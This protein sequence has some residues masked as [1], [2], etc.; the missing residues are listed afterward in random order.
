LCGFCRC[1][2]SSP[3]S[4]R[5]IFS[6]SPLPPPKSSVDLVPAPICGLSAFLLSPPRNELETLL[7]FHCSSFYG[8]NS[9]KWT[10]LILVRLFSEALLPFH[11]PF[12]FP[13][14]W[15]FFWGC[16]IAVFS[17]LL[18]LPL[19]EPGIQFDFRFLGSFRVAVFT[20]VPNNCPG[21]LQPFH[22]ANL[23]PSWNG[24]GSTLP[25]AQTAK[26]P[27]FFLSSIAFRFSLS[28]F[29][30]T[31]IPHPRGRLLF[32]PKPFWP[33][34]TASGPL[35]ALNLFRCNSNLLGCRAC[36]DASLSF[37]TPSRQESS[38]DTPEKDFVSSP[39]LLASHATSPFI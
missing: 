19:P 23:S 34:R 20:C 5:W 31:V 2:P 4:S 24:A 37:L 18:L 32:A 13:Q 11:S 10:D 21:A 27:S 30:R 16:A 7:R 36:K 8:F 1:Q 15:L 14:H 12:L 22:L 26:L 35:D 9:W 17:R 3:S 25:G 38:C 6:L 39:K 29:F 33:V 28:P